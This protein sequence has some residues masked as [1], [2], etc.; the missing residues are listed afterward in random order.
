MICLKSYPSPKIYRGGVPYT[1]NNPLTIGEEG[2]VIPANTLIEQALQIVNGVEP[3]IDL[4][5]IGIT[6][7][8]YGVITPSVNTEIDRITITHGLGTTPLL[9]IIL[10]PN[11]SGHDNNYINMIVAKNPTLFNQGNT[12]YNQKITLAYAYYGNAEALSHS[13]DDATINFSAESYSR[14]RTWY[15]SATYRW[16]AFA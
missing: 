3:G 10:S 16:V 6:K 14:I 5:T 1:G 9:F 8:S 11:Y 4:G 7:S 13:A 12:Y 15:G 2:A